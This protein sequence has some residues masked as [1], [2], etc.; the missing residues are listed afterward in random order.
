MTQTVFEPRSSRAA[1]RDE[2][3]MA[4]LGYIL[5]LIGN[6]IGITSII[7]AIIAYARKDAA[8]AWLHSH[9]VYLIRTF[10]AALFGIIACSILVAT[11]ILSPFGLL[12]FGL[13]WLWVLVRS[14]IGLIRLIN[15]DGQADT[16]GYWV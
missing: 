5:M 7:A 1:D 12:G 14:I 13:V 6:I 11:V 8:P 2:R 3:L 16:V 4:G 9:Y 15:G 10:W